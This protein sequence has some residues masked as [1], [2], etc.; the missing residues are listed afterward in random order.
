[1]CT[2]KSLHALFH[3]IGLRSRK[4]F[5][6]YTPPAA[7]FPCFSHSKLSALK[8]IT[9]FTSSRKPSMIPLNKVSNFPFLSLVLPFTL[10]NVSLRHHLLGCLNDRS[11]VL[12]SCISHMSPYTVQAIKKYPVLSKCLWNLTQVKL[13][14]SF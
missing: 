1:M 4:A 13:G 9:D 3:G 8:V 6:C 12:F 11:L 14:I 5:A 7:F 10:L 2:F